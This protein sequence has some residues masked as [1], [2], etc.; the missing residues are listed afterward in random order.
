MRNLK[1][2]RVISR[3]LGIGLCLLVGVSSAHATNVAPG[4]VAPSTGSGHTS[5]YVDPNHGSMAGDGSRAHPWHTLAEV[6][7]VK[8]GL[9]ANASA[10]FIA[11]LG[12]VKPR[13]DAPI[14]SGDTIYL[15]SG[16]HGNILLQGNF[17]TD[18][19]LYGYN[20]T[21]FVIVAAAPG[22][23][24]VISQMTLKGVNKWVFRGIT[25]ESLQ[26]VPS[27]KGQ[28]FTNKIPG[29]NDYFLI[30]MAGPNSNVVFENDL[31]QSQS[32]TSRWTIGDWLSKRVSGLTAVGGKCLSITGNRFQNIGFAI[33]SQRGTNVLIQGNVINRFT[34]DGIDFGSNNMDIDHNQITN[35]IDDGDGFH[36]DGM[37]GQPYGNVPVS[38]VHITSNYVVN[39]TEPLV[40]P[41][42]LQGIDAFDGVWNRVRILN[43]VVITNAYH[44]ITFYGVDDIWVVNNTVLASGGPNT[45]ININPSKSGAASQKASVRNNLATFFA[46]NATPA[47]VDHNMVVTVNPNTIRNFKASGAIATAMNPASVLET[48]DPTSFR[49]DLR[50][51]QSPAVAL[52]GRAIAPSVDIRGL[53]RT[54]AI[55]L[56]AFAYGGPPLSLQPH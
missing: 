36:Q 11:G 3:S 32:D 4:C 8:R 5:F 18:S 26:N 25:F 39:Q 28:P 16:N 47:Y 50:L 37:Q 41:A 7:D 49:Y 44:G 33:G 20:N 45:W 48:F 30:A 52:G 12:I 34:D 21:D 51:R 23:T 56:G 10:T 43:N 19:F 38:E 24:P 27:N 9:V 31:F 40:S 13:P 46:I 55:D 29:T 1:F 14:R 42:N 17:G 22:Q 2:E 53:S 35:S 15:M 54:K 6:F